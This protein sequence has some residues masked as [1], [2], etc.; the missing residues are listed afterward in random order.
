MAS[1]SSGASSVFDPPSSVGSAMTNNH[2]GTVN[3]L[4][5]TTATTIASA[6]PEKAP[7]DSSKLKTFLGILRQFIGVSDIATVRFSL[8]AQLLEPTPNLE[9]WNYLDRPETFVSIGKSDDHLG[10]M[11]EVLRFWFTKDLK[12]IKGKPCKPY[13][14]VLGEFFRC[15]WEIED[16]ENPITTTAHTSASSTGGSTTVDTN[17]R[18]KI[19]YLTEQTSHHPPVSAFYVDCPQRGIT[20]RGFDQISAKFTGTSIRVTPGQHNLGIF[21]TLRERDNEEYQLTHPAAHLGG[22]LR[23]TLSITVADTCFITCAKTR[24]KA[25]LQYLDEGWIGKAQNRVVGAIF[26]YDPENDTKFKIKDVPEADILARIEGCW[27]EKIY[28]TLTTA[29]SNK[30]NATKE[31]DKDREQHLLIDIAP[32][33]QVS[34]LVPPDDQQLP[35]ESRKF[36]SRVTTAIGEKQYSLAT[37]LKQ[38]LEEQQR[39][40]DSARKER[41]VEWKPLFFT[42]PVASSGKPELTEEGEKVL[43]GLHEGNFRLEWIEDSCSGEPREIA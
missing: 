41:S 25:I 31:K 43:M 23:G 29:G 36:W 34:K 39:R 16:S 7:D 18:V 13:N 38:E 17:G 35:N 6:A 20:A 14:S 5:S 26:S 11:L 19:S 42:V 12:Y 30:C 21:V 3:S 24:I 37:K 9:Y 15:N 22:L 4:G 10:R 27:H 2:N 40:L 32:L 8:P 28:Y 1:S 33:F